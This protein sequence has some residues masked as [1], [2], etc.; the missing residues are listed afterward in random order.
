VARVIVTPRAVADLRA[1]IDALGLP[2]DALRRVQRSLRT[3]ER[4][5]RAGRVLAG[6]WAGTRF[7]VGPWSWMV[8]VYVPD[9]G[10][11]AVFVVAAHDAR[12]SSAAT[13][14]P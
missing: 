14:P 11:D 2:P 5:P 9:E 12:S 6:R 3:L 4:F 8:L 7:L 13:G 1:M 10:D